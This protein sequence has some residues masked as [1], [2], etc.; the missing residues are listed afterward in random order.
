MRNRD[1]VVTCWRITDCG[2]SATSLVI[3]TPRFIG[4]GCIT[5]ASGCACRRFSRLTPQSRLERIAV[6]RVRLRHALALDA[7]RHHHVGALMP[8]ASE[9]CREAP[10]SSPAPASASPDSPGEARHPDG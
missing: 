6:R 9:W 2:P 3:S 8:S 1:A 7:Q 5:I 4:P 10:S